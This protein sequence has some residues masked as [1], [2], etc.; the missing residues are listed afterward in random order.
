MMFGSG[1]D[2]GTFIEKTLRRLNSDYATYDQAA[3]IPDVRAQQNGAFNSGDF[4]FG[5]HQLEGHDRCSE[6]DPDIDGCDIASDQRLD[7]RGGT[8]YPRY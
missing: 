1:G 6:H 8:V 7:R 2:S 5:P 3:D 4:P